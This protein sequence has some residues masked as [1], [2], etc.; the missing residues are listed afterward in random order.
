MET[1]IFYQIMST[2]SAIP[3]TEVCLEWQLTIIIMC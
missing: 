2:K 1:T 3:Y